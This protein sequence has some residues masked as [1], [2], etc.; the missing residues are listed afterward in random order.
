MERR[1]TC[2]G[3]IVGA[4][5]PT[6]WAMETNTKPLRVDVWSDVVCPWCWIGKGRLREALKAEGAPEVDIH[7]HPFLLDPE[8]P[9]D[10]APVP[11]REAYAKK[12]GG[13]DKVEQILT[14]TQDTAQAEGLPM[15]FS[16]G[17]VRASTRDAH[18]L[19]LLA[20]HEGVADA[21]GESLFR[22]HFA[23]GR[24]IADHAVLADV[25]ES[26]GLAR[27]LVLDFLA[28]DAG[29]EEVDAEVAQAQTLGIRAVP[30]FVFDGQLA[31]QGAQPPELFA[32]IFEKLGHGVKASP[33]AGSDD[34]AACGPDGCR[35]D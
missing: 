14:Q 25:G 24:N 7:W 2:A 17:Q 15:D 34:G 12:F 30:T 22:A 4:N 35:I 3:L 19:M 33:E 13:A 29:K 31:V 1:G 32:E 20:T 11:L 21:V 16:R 26:A 5:G 9:A 23:E 18:R 6:L 28:S 8:L 27:Q 10:A